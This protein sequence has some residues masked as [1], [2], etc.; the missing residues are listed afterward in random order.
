MAT[1]LSVDEWAC[2]VAKIML[3]MQTINHQVEYIT[4]HLVP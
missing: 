3:A 2:Q 4:L 1:G